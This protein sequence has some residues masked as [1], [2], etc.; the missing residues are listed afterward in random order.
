MISVEGLKVEFGVKPLFSDEEV[1]TNIEEPMTSLI[2]PETE[3]YNT[4]SWEEAPMFGIFRVKQT[5]EI[6]GDVSTNER[7]VLFCPLWLLFII[8]FAIILVII[9]INI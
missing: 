5:I 4:Q 2:L 9:F 3:R 7:L 1:Y 8:I 6:F